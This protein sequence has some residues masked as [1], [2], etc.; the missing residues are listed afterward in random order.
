M[1]ASAG[2]SNAR[3]ADCSRG[4]HHRAEPAGPVRSAGLA[5]ESGPLRC[6]LRVTS[7]ARRARRPPA[8]GHRR[9]RGSGSTGRTRPGAARPGFI[10][11]YIYSFL[12]TARLVRRAR[13]AGGTFAVVQACNPP[14]IS[15][16]SR[17]RCAPGTGPGSC[18]T[19]T[20]CAPSSTSRGSPAARGMAT[21]ACARLFEAAVC[22]GRRTGDLDQ[23]L[24]SRHRGRARAGSRSGRL[25]GV[26]TSRTRRYRLRRDLTAHQELRA[27]DVTRPPTSAPCVRRTGWTT[28][29]GRWTCGAR[30]GRTDFAFV[31]IGSGDSTDG[32]SPWR[33][34]ARSRPATSELAGFVRRG[35]RRGSCPPPTSASLR[36]LEPAERCVDLDQV[37]G[38]MAL[39]LPV[40]SFDLLETRRYLPG[41]PRCTSSPT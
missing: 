22:T 12:A 6:G 23:R 40:V 34:A 26:R 17:W 21:G 25:H 9:D 28:P 14:D 1:R 31:L 2:G 13:R 29:S 39:G 24:L 18:S 20:T 4:P 38:Y 11:E 7:S 3:A 5:R 19:T 8:R 36:T 33:H 32:W 15:G 27:D 37:D 35:R 16:R 41:T 10:L 30:L